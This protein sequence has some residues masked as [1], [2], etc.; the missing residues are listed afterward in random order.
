[1]AAAGEAGPRSRWIWSENGRPD[2]DRGGEEADRPPG[3]R[4][5]QAQR[6]GGRPVEQ[7]H[8]GAG[9]DEHQLAVAPAP[10]GAALGHRARR[11]E[12]A[13][14]FEQPLRSV[15]PLPAGDLPD[16]VGDDEEHR[17]RLTAAEQFRRRPAPRGGWAGW[18]RCG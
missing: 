3:G 8:V 14:G 4:P 7:A 16:V 5:E 9:L 11:G 18:W 12:F 1:M 13:E 6:A 2:P 15:K 10:D 17:D